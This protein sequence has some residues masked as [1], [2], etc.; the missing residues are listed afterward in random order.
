MLRASI[1]KT[2]DIRYASDKSVYVRRGAQNLPVRDTEG[3]RRLE[4]SKGVVSFESHPL[5]IPLEFVTNS[6]VVIVFM[7]EVV[8]VAEP[9]QWLR[10]QLLIRN[11]K[12][13]V[14]AALLFSDE[15][16]AALPKQSGL[17]V[18][19]YATTDKNGTRKTLKGQPITVEGCLYNQIYSAVRETARMVEGIQ[20][21]GPSGLVDVRYPDA[22]LHEIIA[23]A[24]IH[25]D[26]SM[27]DDIH[28]RVFDN[29][30]EVESP[31]RRQPT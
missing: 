6:E 22:T 14:A 16:Q 28:V 9:E 24:A 4:Y 3:L 10:K 19:R 26:Y 13:T 31:G 12:P 18:Y 8:P 11:G 25:R 27:A 23:N 7:L 29:R 17:K 5:D 2:L 20:I 30:I 1:R 21:M 15:P